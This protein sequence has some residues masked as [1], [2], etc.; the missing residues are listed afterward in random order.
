LISAAPF[1]R[2]RRGVLP[3]FPRLLEGDGTLSAR[4]SGQTRWTPQDGSSGGPP[5]ELARSDLAVS[6]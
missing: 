4:F 6:T 1:Q 2:V 5:L 3:L